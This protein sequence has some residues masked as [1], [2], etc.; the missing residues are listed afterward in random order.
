VI[1]SL[2]NPSVT[3]ALALRSRRRREHA[4]RFLVEGPGAVAEAIE[5]G[6]AETVFATGDAHV[7]PP[8]ARDGLVVHEVSSAVMRRLAGTVTPQGP[9]AVCRFVDVPIEVLDL[10]HGPVVV[11]VEVRDPGN[12]GTI[13]RTADAAGCSGVVVSARSVDV[14][15]EKVARASAGSL[16]HVPVTRET[17]P[18]VALA[19]LGE[20]GATILAASTDGG[21]DLYDDDVGAMLAG[22]VA[23]AFGNEAHGLSPAVRDA[24]R[25][26]VRIPMPGS[27]ESLN[28]AAAVAVIL[29]EAA[30]RRRDRGSGT[31][32]AR[33]LNA[34]V[35]LDPHDPV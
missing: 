17:E 30:R 6:S 32:A 26:A 22:P 18:E 10:A 8:L 5:A 2:H 16:F 13:I 34:G 4:R 28:L 1:T 31:E 29:F 33:R 7:I 20:R 21:S 25:A 9:V 3:E 15:N 19:A 35:G 14:Y 27:A 23:L 12:M 11:L 24:A